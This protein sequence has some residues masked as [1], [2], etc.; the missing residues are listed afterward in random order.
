MTKLQMPK[1]VFFVG[2]FFK[3]E[4]SGGNHVTLLFC[5]NHLVGLKSI[6]DFL[7]VLLSRPNFIL[8]N[9]LI[10]LVFRPKMLFLIKR[11]VSYNSLWEN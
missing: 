5:T 9:F 4:V 3:G 8:R 11:F 2:H 7:R 10:I 1:S 6:I